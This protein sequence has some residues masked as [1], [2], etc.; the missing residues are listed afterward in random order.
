MPR[1][2]LTMFERTNN[3]SLERDPLA[4]CD[5]TRDHQRRA[6][7][8]VRKHHFNVPRV[9]RANA[10]FDDLLHKRPVWQIGALAWVYNSAA[11]PPSYQ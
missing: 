5:L 6:D 10:A 9:A 11:T 3:H 2:P 8:L 1:L 7:H 4:Y